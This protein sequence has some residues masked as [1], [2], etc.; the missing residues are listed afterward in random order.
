[1]AQNQAAGARSATTGAMLQYP[2]EWGVV[3]IHG[4]GGDHSMDAIF[5]ACSMVRASLGQNGSTTSQGPPGT[6]GP[7][8][9]EPADVRGPMTGKKRGRPMSAATRA[10]LAEAQRKRQEEIRRLQKAQNKG[11]TSAATA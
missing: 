4:P 7:S 2:T 9:H 11:K 5:Q 6:T 3:S 8:T 1:M 10:K